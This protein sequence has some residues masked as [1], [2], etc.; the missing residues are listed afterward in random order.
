MKA[1]NEKAKETLEKIQNAF[2]T[3]EVLVDTLAN[4]SLIPFD[5][6]CAKWSPV[7]RFMVALNGTSDARGYRQWQ[8]AERQVRK[9]SKAF[10][11]CVPRFAKVANENSDGGMGDEDGGRAL[12][13]FLTAPVFRL[14]DT[15]GEPF[16]LYSPKKLPKIFD[17]A[18]KMG[19]EARYAGAPSD[20]IA[21]V[22]S[23]QRDDIT[24]YTEGL[25]TFYHELSHADHNRIGKLRDS[26]D[27]SGKR[28][29][30]TVAEIAAAVLVRIFEGE[31]CG[32]QAIQYVKSYD[33]KEK[34]LSTLI[35]E[36]L[37]VVEFVINQV[38]DAAAVAV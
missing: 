18:A 13:G 17:V 35:P 9:G 33:C 24:L 32:R 20:C 34:H 16:S 1:L 29:N 19:I 12:V 15:D 27:K 8:K 5:S 38:D 30:E 2:E 21:G 25:E 26:S 3:P 10:Y 7:N 23:S 4:A 36:I 37:E 31:E 11:I 6:P 14:E 28:T 22:Y